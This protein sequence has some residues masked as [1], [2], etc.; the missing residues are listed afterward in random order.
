MQDCSGEAQTVWDVLDGAW[1]QCH[2]RP[3]LLPAQR[4][5][6]GLLGG[7]KSASFTLKSHTRCLGAAAYVVSISTALSSSSPTALPNFHSCLR[8]AL[9]P[10]DDSIAR[11]RWP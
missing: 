11:R 3:P 8:G 10:E 6:R 1:R 5:V 7:S 9:R 2:H 4:Q